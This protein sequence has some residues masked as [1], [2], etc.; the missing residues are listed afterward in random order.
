M[1]KSLIAMAVAGAFIAPS[2]MADVTV[3]GLAQ[4]EIYQVKGEASGSEKQRGIIDNANG[5]V[6]VKASEDLGNGWKALAKFEFKADTVD[7]TVGNAGSNASLS[8]RESMVGL[9]GS[10]GQFEAGRLKSAYKYTGGVKYDAFVA[11]ALEA[12]DNA[13]MI[14]GAYGAGGFL[15]SSLGYVNKFGPVKVWATWGPTTS[16]GTRT[17]S[18]AFMDKGIEAFAAVADNG[19]PNT[20]DHIKN[21][22]VGGSF[23]TGGHKVMIQ[24]E[25]HEVTDTGGNKTKD[26]VNYLAYH[27]KFGMNKF[28]VQLGN[29]KDDAGD[30]DS[31]LALGVRHMLGSMKKTELYAG[32]RSTKEKIIVDGG[33]NV[34]TVGMIKKF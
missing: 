12:R 3:Y 1:K 10:A 8:G 20:G 7:N 32:Y 31:Y 34:I 14:G 5:R 11:T 19:S 4:A 17:L 26:K 16:D 9:K 15:S 13:G 23:K 24:L 30:K 28:I 21:T 25:N 18:A 2:A 29:Y 33:E 22:K 27:G 6:G